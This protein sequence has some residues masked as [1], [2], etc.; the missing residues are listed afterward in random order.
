[1]SVS[2]EPENEAYLK[3]LVAEGVY[4]SVEEAVDA[5]IHALRSQDEDLLW[6][7][8]FVEEGLAQLE[9][10]AS[11]PADQV[12]SGLRQKLE[13]KSRVTKHRKEIT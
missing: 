1:M 12:F 10:D 6:A 3:R 11:V 8:P 9:R 7:K 4:S 5:A 2:I 13:T